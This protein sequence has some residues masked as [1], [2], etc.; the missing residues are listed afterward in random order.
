MNDICDTSIF[1]LTR[2]YGGLSREELRAR[3]QEYPDERGCLRRWSDYNSWT[4]PE[5]PVGKA[6]YPQTHEIQ[7]RYRQS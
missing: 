7:S 6:L 2:R 1:F 3:W 4:E 5:D